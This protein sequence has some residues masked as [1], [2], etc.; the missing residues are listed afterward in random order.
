MIEL[1][2][3]Y[4]DHFASA[5][6]ISNEAGREVGFLIYEDKISK[7][8]LGEKDEIDFSVLE[9]KTAKLSFHTHLSGYPYP[10]ETDFLSD[11]I[12]D[13]DMCV[14][15]IGRLYKL[16]PYEYV[17]Y[18]PRYKELKDRYFDLRKEMFEVI[19]MEKKGLMNEYNRRVDLHDKKFY[20]L[21][22]DIGMI[23]VS[24]LHH[25]MPIDLEV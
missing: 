20:S 4:V 8:V 14:I 19:E 1:I 11:L 17:K 25:R 3:R 5:M 13:V 21:V 7:Y 15:G 6:Y 16:Y 12:F 23:M 9:E 24:L 10:S 18:D 2:E 22:E